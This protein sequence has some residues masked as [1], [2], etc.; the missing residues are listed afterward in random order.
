MRQVGCWGLLALLAIPLTGCHH[1]DLV[2]A[3][4]RYRNR[5]V[6]ELRRQISQKSAEVHTLEAMMKGPAGPCNSPASKETPDTVYRREAMS[7]VSLAMSTGIKDVDRNGIDDSV[8]FMI[9]CHDYDGD[10]FKCPGQVHLELAAVQESGVI[11]PVADWQL[12]TDRLRSTW[13]AS[14]LAN[15][16]QVIVPMPALEQAKRWKATVRFTTLDGRVFQDERTFDYRPKN[17]SPTS[18]DFPDSASPNATKPIP[19]DPSGTSPSKLLTDPP[20]PAPLAPPRI[21]EPIIDLP[22]PS[23]TS[24]SEPLSDP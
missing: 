19:T 15:G 21:E 13:K 2:E 22:L 4:L 18:E 14:I 9:V 23:S 17:A 11:K 12:E 16:Y 1:R 10:A 7:R 20:A 6:R 8:Q 24:P 3:E 5:Q